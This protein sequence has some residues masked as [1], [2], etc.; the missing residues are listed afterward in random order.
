MTYRALTDSEIATLTTQGCLAEDWQAVQVAEPFHPERIQ[1]VRLAG[2][3]RIGVLAG[4]VE[5]AGGTTVPAGLYD[6]TIRDCTIGDGA[7]VRGVAEMSGYDV[8]DGAVVSNV[9]VLA[10]R[11][12]TTF[13]N[14][15]AIEILNEGGGRP[16]KIFDRLSA[17][18]AYVLVLY[19]HAPA[20]IERLEKL[21]DDYVAS[22]R[23]DRGAVAAGSRVENSGTIVNVSVG[24]NVTISGAAEL[25]EGTI[26]G[27]PDDPTVIGTG[28]IARDFI[29]L[30][31]SRVEDG[32]ILSHC[33]VGQA[34][35][36]GR[37]F[38]AENSA[39]FANCEAFHGEACSVFAG[40]Y[41]VTHHK[42]TLLIAGMFSFYNAGSASNQSN[43]MYKL[44]PLHQGICM[45]G[46]KTS[47]SS[48]LLWPSRVGPF[49]VVVG[50]HMT[51]FDLATLPFSYVTAEGERTM[52]IP[53]MNLFTVGTLRDSRKWPARDRRKDPQKLDLLHFDLFSPYVV[54]LALDGM[55]TLMQLHAATP[56][57]KE[58]AVYH[59]ARIARALLKRSARQYEIVVRIFLGEC[60]AGLL[61]S[62]P[63]EEAKR[64]LAEFKDA[65]L[66]DWADLAGMFAPRPAVEELLEAVASGKLADL[67]ELRRR[68]GRIHE[69]YDDLKLRWCAALLRDHQGVDPAAVTG[70]QLAGIIRDWRDAAL[71]L[72]RMILIDARKEFD[73]SSKI[74][75]G[76]DGDAETTEKDFTAVRGTFEDNAFV[77]ALREESA[78]IESRADGLL[79]R[80]AQ[81]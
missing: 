64:R 34:A 25:R 58:T 40:P 30:S 69:S 27:C 56:K 70:E 80:L 59:G 75:F 47:S 62:A 66:S 52:V 12:P 33:F 55:E 49:S 71:K 45:R 79:E 54:K 15:T 21:I 31:G 22:K 48:Y 10:V 41:T 24:P 46:A 16:L 63:L 19:R 61:E 4:E 14:G 50:K 2:T 65:E 51:N 76:I 20:V 3:V 60:L 38:S 8:G 5:L 28:V 35:R 43:H 11:G 72:N 67:D 57:D 68:L 29:V 1:R 23:S 32:S 7:C 36:I 42:S 26:L 17:Q 53:A 81:D 37:Q 78:R 18:L 13:G 73:P 39:F 6:S 9:A 77:K 44:G 74:G